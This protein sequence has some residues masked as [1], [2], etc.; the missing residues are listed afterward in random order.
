[1]IEKSTTLS[2]KFI[3]YENMFFQKKTYVFNDCKKNDHAIDVENIDFL[4]KSLYNLLILKLQI[5]R[6]YLDNVLSKKWIRH[7]I[8]FAKT[9]IFF[10]FKK[11]DELRLCVNYQ[12]LNKIIKKNQHS[13]FLIT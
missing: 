11:N 5:L 8:N 3:D 2:K 9:L 6:K 7:S 4:Y 12:K 10:V 13:F 1:M